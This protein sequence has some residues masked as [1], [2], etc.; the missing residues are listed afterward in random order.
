M[1]KYEIVREMIEKE[2]LDNAR[3]LD[4]LHSTAAVIRYD[5]HDVPDLEDELL[6][7][8]RMLLKGENQ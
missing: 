2:G 6:N 8:I 4:W 5:V 1:T 7:M 3:I